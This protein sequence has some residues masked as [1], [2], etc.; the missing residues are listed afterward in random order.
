MPQTVYFARSGKLLEI[1]RDSGENTFTATVLG[2][3]RTARITVRQDNV[4]HHGPKD[5]Y[6]MR[7]PRRWGWSASID[8][9]VP[10]TNAKPPDDESGAASDIGAVVGNIKPDINV[11]VFQAKIID[12]RTFTGYCH[13]GSGELS[14]GDDPTGEA[15]ELES[16]GA[17]S[18]E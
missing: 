4:E 1:A 17:F 14:M 12:G 2:S 11:L 8:R 9:F 5:S 18:L 3:F 13:F 6:D 16:T 15:L 7:T 10:S